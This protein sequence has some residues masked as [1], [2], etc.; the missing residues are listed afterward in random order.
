MVAFSP[1]YLDML[2]TG[3]MSVTI[4]RMTLASTGDVEIDADPATSA[5]LRYDKAGSLNFARSS[6]SGLLLC[7]V[8]LEPTW[9]VGILHPNPA[10]PF[11]TKMLPGI[12][13]GEVEVDREADQLRIRW[14][15]ESHE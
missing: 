8:S 6:I 13:F 1:P 12:S 9:V 10:R 14:P 5:F 11:D 2:L 7:G 15:E 3:T 4:E